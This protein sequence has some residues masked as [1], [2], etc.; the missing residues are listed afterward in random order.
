MATAI[1]GAKYGYSN[2]KKLWIETIDK[3]NSVNLEQYAIMLEK[4][5][6]L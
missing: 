3:H 5:K 4:N 2:F 1:S 6:M